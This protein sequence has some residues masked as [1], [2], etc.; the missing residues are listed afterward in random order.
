M[1]PV[2]RRPLA[3]GKLNCVPGAMSVTNATS[4]SATTPGVTF[5]LYDDPDAPPPDWHHVPTGLDR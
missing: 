1:A 2:S 5:E 4:L 3:S